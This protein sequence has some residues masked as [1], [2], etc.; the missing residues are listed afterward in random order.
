MAT[1]KAA[2]LVLGS[3]FEAALKHQSHGGNAVRDYGTI[4]QLQTEHKEELRR[5]LHPKRRGWHTM[6]GYARTEDELF[7]SCLLN[8]TWENCYEQ[9]CSYTAPEPAA[10]AQMDPCQEKKQTTPCFYLPPTFSQ[11]LTFILSFSPRT[12]TATDGDEFVSSGK[13][14]G[15]AQDILKARLEAISMIYAIHLTRRPHLQHPQC[16]DGGRLKRFAG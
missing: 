3:N 8:L 4:K 15:G 16:L 14:R 6:D 5:L 2:G 7:S 9:T 1:I 11:L 12:V 10:R 13:L